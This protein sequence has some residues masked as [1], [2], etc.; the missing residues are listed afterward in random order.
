VEQ[1][2]FTSPESG[3]VPLI[4]SA[5][6]PKDGTGSYW[7][8]VN[9]EAVPSLPSIGSRRS[10]G[11]QIVPRIAV[12]VIIT[13]LGTEHISVRATAIDMIAAVESSGLEADI[14]VENN[15]N[16]AVLL[17][18]ALALERSS[19]REWEELTSIDVGPVTSLPGMK[20]KVKGLIPWNGAVNGLQAH[21]YLRYGPNPDQTLE[22]TAAVGWRQG[23][24]AKR[25]DA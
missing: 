24:P 1:R 15:G 17:S 2:E 12:P 18:G 7:A 9:L 8:L 22:A 6:I 4:V 5:K 10:V 23:G 3:T 11:L 16:T 21:A 13:V 19:G 14:V 20:V 25:P